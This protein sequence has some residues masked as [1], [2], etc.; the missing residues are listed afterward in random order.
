MWTKSIF[1]PDAC[2]ALVFVYLLTA[3]ASV[4]ADSSG[5]PIGIGMPHELDGFEL[6]QRIGIGLDGGPSLDGIT[7]P[8]ATGMQPLGGH[9]PS[10]SA[11]TKRTPLLDGSEGAV[12]TLGVGPSHDVEIPGDLIT[13]TPMDFPGQI[14]LQSPQGDATL[15]GLTALDAA[16][17]ILEQLQLQSPPEDNTFTLPPA[18]RHLSP[19]LTPDLQSDLTHMLTPRRPK[20]V[21]VLLPD[22][23]LDMPAERLSATVTGYPTG[24]SLDGAAL[25]AA[26]DDQDGYIGVYM[27]FGDPITGEPELPGNFPPPALA[28]PAGD[29]YRDNKVLTETGALAVSVLS[30]SL[31]LIGADG[32]IRCSAYPLN[33]WTLITAAHCACARSASWRAT[34]A[35]SLRSLHLGEVIELDKWTVFGGADRCRQNCPTGECPDDFYQSPDIAV[36]TLKSP[37]SMP[38]ADP[39]LATASQFLAAEDIYWVGHGLQHGSGAMT[40]LTNR[41]G[42]PQQIL[43]PACETS[44]LPRNGCLSG[45]EGYFS[46]HGRPSGPCKADSG[47]MGFILRED[48]LPVMASLVSREAENPDGSSGCGLGGIGSLLFTTDVRTFLNGFLGAHQLGDESQRALLASIQESDGQ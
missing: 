30:Q 25:L 43:S 46:H 11:G 16:S 5:F 13:T 33:A 23:T 31:A 14:L 39:V 32:N 40:A 10:S 2:A 8:G 36:V 9:S 22:R 21:D 24:I 35:H 27:R 47:G 42:A 45:A 37:I 17:R 15:S 41:R 6:D 20:T 18:I 28:L 26:V 1:V 34:T 19:D 12:H 7:I 4:N 29:L 38:L 48:G 44:P 3:G